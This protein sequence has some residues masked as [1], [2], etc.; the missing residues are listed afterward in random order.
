MDRDYD[1]RADN[2][3][4]LAVL[5]IALVLSFGGIAYLLGLSNQPSDRG[6]VPGVGGGPDNALISPSPTQTPAPA[7][8][9]TVTEEPVIVPPTA[10]PTP[11][12]Q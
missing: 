4:W 2:K 11:T 6:V 8:T 12:V 1:R 9:P 3:L 7:S 10:V 5:A